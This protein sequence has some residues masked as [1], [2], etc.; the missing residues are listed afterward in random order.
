VS[1]TARPPLFPF[2]ALVGLD[3]LKLALQ[4][5][6]IDAR[7][8]VLVRG[9]K[10]AGKTTAARGLAALLAAGAPFVTLPIGATE[11][12]LLGGLDLERA[13]KG[14]PALKP[15]VLADA[16][17]GVLYIDEVNLLPDHLADALLDA[18]ASG[19]HVVE[20]EGFSVTQITN[21]VMIGSMNP[22]E[23][24]LRPQLL[25]RFALAV[26]VEAPLDPHVR[27][28]VLERRL[29]YD[30]DP[31]RF[32]ERWSQESLVVRQSLA[33]A[34]A[35]LADLALPRELLHEIA[36]RVAACGVRSLRADL[37]VMRASR[38]CAALEGAATVGPEHVE[39]VLP[40]AIA[41]RSRSLT[42]PSPPPAASPPHDDANADGPRGTAAERVFAPVDVASAPRVM[43]DREGAGNRIGRGPASASMIVDRGP[44]IGTRL[45]R[46]PRELDVR[47]SLLHAMTRHNAGVSLQPDDLHEKTREPRGDTRFIVIVDSSGSHAVHERMTL[48]KGTITALLDA[49]HARRDEMVVIVCR[50]AAA[51][52]L[53]EPTTSRADVE[54]AL[55]YLPT[56]GRT[57]LAHALELAM[58]HVTDRALLLL[59]TDGHANVPHGSEDAW[60]DALTA[61]RIVRCP[62]LVIDSEDP[63]RATGRARDIADAMGATYARLGDLDQAAVLRIVASDRP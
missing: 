18:V 45:T 14:E 47:P 39:R 61:A 5:A 2:A 12:R 33:D 54:R 22:E 24:S 52:V 15:G 6:A 48:V 17:G 62:A 4:L 55:E 13:L 40:L 38:A 44:V 19:L 1:A 11:D 7:L 42:R 41:H 57:P 34:R 21:F 27:G 32:E 59:V 25:D 37:A 10:G 46:D 26:E 35:R 60:T 30:T 9:D 50:G 63:R 53:V 20:R 36:T 8:S 23:G 31:A 56:G 28:D 51:S 58:T 16:H 43:V 3:T 49:S 29:Q